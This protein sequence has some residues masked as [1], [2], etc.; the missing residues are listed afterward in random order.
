MKEDFIKMQAHY[1]VIPGKALLGEIDEKLE[2]DLTGRLGEPNHRG[3]WVSN[4]GHLRN[5]FL[6]LCS[7]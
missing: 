3:E 6:Q 5:L 1:W 4:L 2:I 7:K